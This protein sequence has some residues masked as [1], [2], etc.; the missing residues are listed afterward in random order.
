MPNNRIT[1][2][3]HR[4]HN[5]IRTPKQQTKTADSRSTTY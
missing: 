2:N 1:K 5:N 4:Q 3:P